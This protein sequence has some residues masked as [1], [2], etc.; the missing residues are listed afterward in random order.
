M[1]FMIILEDIFEVP[2]TRLGFASPFSLQID[3]KRDI[4]FQERDKRK[5]CQ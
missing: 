4:L 3:F 1:I 5:I 2:G